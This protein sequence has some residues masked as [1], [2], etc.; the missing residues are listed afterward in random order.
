MGKEKIT[1][2]QM[3]HDGLVDAVSFTSFH[4][5]KYRHLYI[6]LAVL[7]TVILLGLGLLKFRVAGQSQEA[8][9]SLARARENLFEL[10]NIYRNFPHTK[11]APLALL[12]SAEI[13][14]RQDKLTES[15]EHFSLFLKEY[16]AHSLAPAARMGIGY[17]READGKWEEALRE[18]QDLE[19][20]FGH[21]YLV[22]EAIFNQGRCREKL[23]RFQDAADAYREIIQVYQQSAFSNLARER[24]VELQSRGRVKET[25]L[26]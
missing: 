10:E 19:R 3:R 14:Y 4:L 23:A 1:R 8:A 20:D 17:C 6:A 7:V 18:Y 22:A 5:Q 11:S 12:R 25:T 16:P 15:R 2:K 26:K 9:S 13:L 24:L 21:S